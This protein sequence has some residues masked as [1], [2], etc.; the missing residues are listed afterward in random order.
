MPTPGD[1]AG[2]GAGGRTVKI[3]YHM[4]GEAIPTGFFQDSIVC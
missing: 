1:T 3:S 4:G 2:T